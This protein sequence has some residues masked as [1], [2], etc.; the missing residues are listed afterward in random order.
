[1]ILKLILISTLLILP[2][3]FSA[4]NS[5]DK[6]EKNN[7]EFNDEMIIGT[8]YFPTDPSLKLVYKSSMG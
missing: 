6:I 1:M 5:V 3:F 4:F 2:I 7:S 8:D